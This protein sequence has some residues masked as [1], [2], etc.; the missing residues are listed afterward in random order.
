MG[1]SMPMIDYLCPKNDVTG[2]REFHFVPTWLEKYVGEH[3][4]A[5]LIDES[6]GELK[7]TDSDGRYIK[8]VQEIGKKL[9]QHSPR[10]G[11]AYEFKVIKSDAD[12][13]WCLPGGKIA[14]NL[15]LIKRMEAEKQKFDAQFFEPFSLEQKIAAVLSHEIIHAAARH[16]GRALE[17]RLFM[18]GIIKVVE[19]W[20]QYI[21]VSRPYTQKIDAAREKKDGALITALTKERDARCQSIHRFFY[22]A[23]SWFIR[24]IT[25]CN[26]R[27]HELESDKYSMIL[28]YKNFE[29]KHAQAA[30]WLQHYFQAHHPQTT[31]VWAAVKNFF[32]THP[33][34]QERLEKNK[35]TWAE[36][37]A[38][39]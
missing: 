2:R 36:L 12:N 19:L 39:K 11:L 22:H 34:H 25:L 21:L 26:S 5:S 28:L 31:G 6:G 38:Q 7:A 17:F 15:G 18:M 14:I 29:P 13:A 1:V 32:S 3:S 33:S 35:K 37:T 9:A 24:G 8:I 16:T 30:L 20:T 4:Y 10:P 23:S 27:S